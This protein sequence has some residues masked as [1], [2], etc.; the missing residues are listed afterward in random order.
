[1]PYSLGVDL[2]TTFVAAAV[3]R[4]SQVEMFTLGDRSVVSPAVVYARDDGS[5]VCGDAAGR[6]AVSRPDRIGREF[7][8]RLGDPTPIMLGGA[9]Y[10]V[11]ALLAT[12][13]R[14]VVERVVETEGGPPERVVLTHPA[15]W[16]PFRRELFD[17]VP[18]L[19]GLAAHPV[20]PRMVT[21]PEA[22]AA[23]YAAS[24]QLVDGDVVAVYDLGGGTFDATVLRKLRDGIEILGTPEGVE[25]LGGVDFDEAILSYVNYA[26]G[27]A[28]T[29]LDMSDQQTSVAMAR[30]RQD[31]ILAKEALS[32]DTETVIPVFLPHRHFDIHLTS[33]D[34]EDMIR[35]QVEST[36]GAFTRTLRSAQV[37]PDE[38]TAV[39]LVGGSSRIPL[40][41]RMISAEL[42]RPI[43][44][45]THPKYAV[46]L[47]AAELARV[48]SGEV[49]VA[50][51]APAVSYSLPAPA[52]TERNGSDGHGA[53]RKAA[54]PDGSPHAG[55]ATTLVQSAA[56]VVA[57]PLRPGRPPLDAPRPVVEGPPADAG[58]QIPAPR[59]A[60]AVG[61]A[62]R[63]GRPPG[64]GG[65][66][67]GSSS[68]PPGAAASPAAS[69]P[70]AAEPPLPPPPLRPP[71]GGGHRRRPLIA[72]AAVVAVLVL[73]GLV[74]AVTGGAL[75]PAAGGATAQ[76]APVPPAGGP[77]VPGPQAPSEV[78]SV[79]I[80][81]LGTSIPAG[82]TSGF[83]AVSPNGRLAYV[84][85][86]AAGVV[87]VIDTAINR[88]TAT[89]AIPAGPPQYLAFS[90]DGRRVY[91][92]VF[93]EERTIAAVAVLD[94]TTNAVV[95]TTPV[96]T[97][98][99][100][101]AVTPDGSRV[102]VPNHDSGTV[103]VI[104]TASN[105]V[106]AE[107]DV[108]PNPHWIAFS[109]DGTRAYAANHESNLIT[110]LDPATDSVLAEVP[111]GTSPHSVAVNPARP[112]VANVNY[113]GGTVSMT[114]TDTR[115][116]VATVVVGKNPQAIAWSADGR[117]AYVV[118]VSDDTLSVISAETFAV[119]AT[120]PTEDGPTSVAV[121]PN[122]RQAYVTNLN[123]GTLTVLDLAG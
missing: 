9:A 10:A 88:T 15:N 28:L 64:P 4:A 60:G 65:A 16:G 71:S 48:G 62:L 90:P 36:I 53:L 47:G 11:T 121:L 123:S 94:T 69:G 2:G 73:A 89:I 111:V 98:P 91:V 85:N 22:A 75:G 59:P 118:N 87:T 58:A 101:L 72:V 116:V 86:R 39:L 74:Y 110:V 79:P 50:A 93:N 35:A 70:A 67:P 25:R 108:A 63:P 12:L 61:A 30:L 82:P 43:V 20:A 99:Y 96:R 109:A 24:H 23:H 92:S 54:A 107:I 52:P 115:E 57:A 37:E 117:Y 83:V 95:A 5:L 100:A 122:G 45:D 27:G 84:A 80:P 120:I 81:T 97:R 46:A 33:T 42:D 103:S 19:A 76:P 7:K 8:R 68:H 44:V 34:F 105:A 17:E 51:G 31:C 40:V 113:D 29:D 3:A 6:R 13:L 32:I 112:L 26:S 78:Q 41:A 66:G 102:Y 56:P 106:S 1:M 104:D 55:A 49:T 119:T 14:D 18:P 77:V 38:L 21:E 114:D